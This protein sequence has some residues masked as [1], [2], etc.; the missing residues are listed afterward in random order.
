MIRHAGRAVPWIRV[1]LACALVALLMELLRWNPW[2]LW[3]LQGTA[4]GLLA[5]ATAWCFDEPAAA[6]VDTLPR[7]AAWRAAARTPALALLL[8]TWTV[9]SLHAGD[10]ALFGHVGDLLVQGLAAMSAGAAMAVWS[11]GRGE[12]TPGLRIAAVAVPVATVWALARPLHRQLPVFPYGTSSEA[13]WQVSTTGWGLLGAV[14]VLVVVLSL[15]DIRGP[16]R[17]R[18][19]EP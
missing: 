17:A 10:E 18:R 5:G 11:R 7:G 14:A 16:G 2:V 4:V 8:A 15:T 9:V 6:V 13:A 1:W 3:P 12:S 19:R